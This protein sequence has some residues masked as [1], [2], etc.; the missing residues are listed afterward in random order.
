MQ[1]SNPITTSAPLRPLFVNSTIPSTLRTRLRFATTYS[2]PTTTTAAS[3]GVSCNDLFDPGTT[4]DSTQ[5]VYFDQL[6]LMYNRY[7]VYGSSIYVRG[8][9]ES[10]AAGVGVTQVGGEMIV[11]PLNGGLP[12]TP[13]TMSD[14]RA[15]NFAKAAELTGTRVGLVNNQIRVA[16]ISGTRDIEGSDRFQAVVSTSPT[17]VCSWI[18]VWNSSVAQ[19]NEQT[20][21]HITVDYDAEFYDRN[22]L[23]RSAASYL[24]FK[25]AL[26]AR[27]LE[28]R[29][30]ESKRL[31]SRK[32]YSP[33]PEIPESG[34]VDKSDSKTESPV[35]VA[36]QL[37]STPRLGLSKGK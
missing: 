23:D 4:L 20:T 35:L 31:T 33:L 32:E 30:R 12:Y 13:T 17:E 18:I 29:D 10:S 9:L 19:S 8:K 28:L 11:F 14:A 27:F 21:F 37:K 1:S 3:I 15:Q 2:A 6:A 25:K 5:P 24:L 36:R 16:E 22:P 7:R 34:F 26:R